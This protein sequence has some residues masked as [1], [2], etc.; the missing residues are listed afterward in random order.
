MWCICEMSVCCVGCKSVRLF[1]SVARG[2]GISTAATSSE[3]NVT[4]RLG[5]CMQCG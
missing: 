2:G 4:V 5:L 1:M 3:R